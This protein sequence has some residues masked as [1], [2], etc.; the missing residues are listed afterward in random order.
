MHETGLALPLG[1]AVSDSWRAARNVDFVI[2]GQFAHGSLEGV[3]FNIDAFE[4]GVRFSGGSRYGVSTRAFGQVL[5][6]V[7]RGSASENLASVGATGFV[8][9]PGFGVD[10]P[11][12]PK[13]DLRPQFDVLIG[14]I[15]GITTKDI[16]FGVNVVFRLFKP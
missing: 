7:V 10:V 6:G 1:I 9:Q 8:V 12:T 14:R 2:E 16:R 4:G 11:M 5:A 15:S 13:V 3:S